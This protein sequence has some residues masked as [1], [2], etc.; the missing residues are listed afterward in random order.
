MFVKCNS[1]IYLWK[2]LSFYWK[3]VASVF[4]SI[5]STIKESKTNKQKGV[6]QGVTFWSLSSPKKNQH[7]SMSIKTASPHVK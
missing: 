1:T 6:K 2:R 4:S 5:F 7:L 3:Y